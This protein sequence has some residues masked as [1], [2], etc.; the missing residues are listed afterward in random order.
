MA[1]LGQGVLQYKPI[2]VSSIL[3]RKIEVSLA[4]NSKR[5]KERAIFIKLIMLH[6]IVKI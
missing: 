6:K 5:L 1:T 2:N 3:G 4:N